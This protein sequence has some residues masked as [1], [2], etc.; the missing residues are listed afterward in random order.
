MR[1][2]RLL[3]ITP[4]LLIGLAVSGCVTRGPAVA[5]E[6]ETKVL[7]IGVDPVYPPLAFEERGEVM[8]MEADLGRRFAASLGREAVFV[9]RRFPDLINALIAGDIDIIMSGM[10]ITR[11]RSARVRFTTPYLRVGQVCLVRRRDAEELLYNLPGFSGKVGVVRGT[12]G[13]LFVQGGMPE[14]ERREF[15]RVEAAAAALIAGRLDIVIHDA[16]SVWWLAS[17]NESRGLTTLPMFLTEEYLAWAVARDNLW[18]LTEA[19]GFIE[20]E[21]VNGVIPGLVER[22]MPL[23]GSGQ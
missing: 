12:T 3:L 22:W 7:R 8:G 15:D 10:S 9:K 16:P 20:A 4:F 17:V 6:E 21:T 2:H 19:N 14:A 23:T 13:D 11:E 1:L 18:L 5:Q